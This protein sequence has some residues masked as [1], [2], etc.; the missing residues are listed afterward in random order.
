MYSGSGA[1]ALG[2]D[3]QQ[4]IS[5]ELYT[6]GQTLLVGDVVFFDVATSKA[7]KSLVLADQ[8][9]LLGVVVG[10]FA[11][12][13]QILQEDRDIG[14]TAALI[15]QPVLVAWGGIVK[16]LSDAA[17][18]NGDR[19]AAATAT[20]AGRVKTSVATNFVVGLALNLAGAGGVVVRVL[21][22]L[23]RTAMT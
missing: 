22:G 13:G 15:N 3:A 16:C 23:T 19:V 7:L 5:A 6:A 2:L 11:T 8:N 4:A 1:P 18:T 21:L 9:K 14:E 10:G 12:A 20:T 17:I